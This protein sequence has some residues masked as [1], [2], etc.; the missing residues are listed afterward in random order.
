MKKRAFDVILLC[1]LVVARIRID[2]IAGLVA[3]RPLE[4]L[5]K[6]PVLSANGL[7]LLEDWMVD[8]YSLL[9]ITGT[10]ACVIVYVLFD[11]FGSSLNARTV[12][13]TKLALIYLI[14]L[15]TVVTQ[16]GMLIYLRQ[17]QG[18]A[19]FT[20][21]GGVIQTEEA[22][23]YIITGKNPYVEDYVDTPMAE[24]GTDLKTALYHFP[25]LPWTFVSAIPFQVATQAV[26][27]WYDQRFVYLL[28]FLVMLWLAPKLTRDP[29]DKL[30][31]TMILG[32]NPIMGNDLIFGQNDSFVLFWIVLT[33]YG[34]LR[35]QWILTGIA[36]GLAIA[37]KSTAWFL[38]PFFLIYVWGAAER[39]PHGTKSLSRT[40]LPAVLV[41]AVLIL[42]FVFW[43]FGAMVDDIWRW[44]SG[45]TETAYQIRGWG[46]A[47]LILALEL[48]TSRLDYFPFWILEAIIGI[49]LMLALLWRQIA[50]DNSV[51]AML[52]G[53]VLFSF[54]FFFFSRFFNEN[55]V[56]FLLA[57]LAL[58]FFAQGASTEPEQIS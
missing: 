6:I 16:A 44:S 5:E 29:T 30:C 28:L 31:L 13:R 12:Y 8:P 41:A 11:W 36:F 42:P 14:V 38:L 22:T 9:L 43:N 49:P 20:H 47:N 50:R 40:L 57:C 18:P 35:Q 15:L 55:Y 39:S 21:D 32:L 23:R 7:H 19:S 46:L 34:L 56:G 45:T 3:P 17:L 4:L 58:G 26:L 24:W 10:F 37:S 25:Y 33:A 1:V 54:V 52:Y 53:Y 2:T 48:V 27:G 51:G